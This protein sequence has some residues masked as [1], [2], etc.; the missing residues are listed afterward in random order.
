MGELHS[1][2]IYCAHTV[3]STTRSHEDLKGTGPAPKGV[4]KKHLCRTQGHMQ[5]CVRQ[6]YT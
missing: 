1:S 5:S 6:L 4:K 2:H 3:C